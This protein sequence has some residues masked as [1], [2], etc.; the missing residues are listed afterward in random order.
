MR[1]RNL[2]VCAI[3]LSLIPV[4]CASPAVTTDKSS[5]NP[6]N[7]VIISG[8][9]FTPGAQVIIEVLSPTGKRVWLDQVPV[10]PQ[11]AFTSTFS[12][13]SDADTGTYTLYASAPGESAQRTFSVTTPTPPPPPPPP[14][15][16]TYI[17]PN[18]TIALSNYEVNFGRS[19]TVFGKITPALSASIAI[20]TSSDG[21]QW[22]TALT[23]TSNSSGHYSTQWYPP[24]PGTFYLRAQFFGMGTY[25]ACI[26]SSV[27]L[28]VLR[29][30]GFLTL[31]PESQR[32]TLGGKASFEGELLPRLRTEIAVRVSTDRTTW[33]PLMSVTTNEM[34]KFSFSWEPTVLGSYFVRAYWAGDE[35]HEG[36]NSPICEVEVV[37]QL[38]LSISLDRKDITVLERANIL[39]S[40]SPAQVGKALLEISSDGAT[41]YR[42][43]E[44]NIGVDGSFSYLFTPT[45]SG[46][47][48]LRA[49]FGEM[50][51]NVETL[52]VSKVSTSMSIS[53]SPQETTLGS[54]VRLNGRVTPAVE[55]I[56]V[57]VVLSGP[58]GS[59]QTRKTATGADG[60]FTVDFVP[61]DTGSWSAVASFA[62]DERYSA[63]TSNVVTFSVSPVPVDI[64]RMLGM[65]LLPVCIILLIL[66]ALVWRRRG[67]LTPPQES[68]IIVKPPPSQST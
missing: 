38:M 55:G 61:V 59:A 17:T 43:S 31:R 5:Y 58:G 50:I 23:T 16:P 64:F 11:G 22:E 28:S 26:S 10:N 54:A 33:T 41:W 3:L 9:G 13:P 53:V 32:L 12:L 48:Y 45:A 51:S 34:G 63:S 8:S 52:S 56:I 19:V 60:S 67:R 25:L 2:L 27:S 36:A 20:M 42:I 1:T 57:D 18:L 44:V 46:T 62:G 4:A 24:R 30:E 21:S 15:P 39:G 65:L 6:G 14:P 35:L 7:T 49:R 40:L 66:L 47:F 29:I 68:T 37:R